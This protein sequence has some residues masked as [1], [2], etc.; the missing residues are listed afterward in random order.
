MADLQHV[1]VMGVSGCGKTT[2][3]EGLAAA[4]GWPFDEGDRFHPAAN[5]AKMSAGHPLDDAD[6]RPWL[7]TL[8]ARLGEKEAAGTSSILACSAL[9]RSY[10]DLLRS[11]APRVRFVHLHGD[12][13][14]LAARLANRKGHFFPPDL[15]DSQFAALEP[16]GPDEDGVVV[17]VALDPEAQVRA[18]LAGLDLEPGRA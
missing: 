7:E 4:L 13:A 8:A 3:G 6:R 15:L 11:G 10:R 9:K 1:V 14:V 2:V 18:A 5:I 12:K 16:L 17:D